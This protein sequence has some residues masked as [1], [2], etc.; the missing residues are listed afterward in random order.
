MLRRHEARSIECAF[1]LTI[2]SSVYSKSSGR[3]YANVF[4]S[5]NS[6]IICIHYLGRGP[7]RHLITGFYGYVI[8]RRTL[9]EATVH[10]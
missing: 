9:Q 1:L 5:S 6:S 10:K 2:L 3:A 7:N 4:V 8:A